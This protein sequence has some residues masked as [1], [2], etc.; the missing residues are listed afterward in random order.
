MRLTA[1]QSAFV[2]AIR[3]FAERERFDAP[4]DGH[5]PEVAAYVRA[6]TTGRYGLTP[7]PPTRRGRR[8]SAW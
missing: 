2:E 1:E 7:A 4:H 6:L 3:D 5:S 8:A